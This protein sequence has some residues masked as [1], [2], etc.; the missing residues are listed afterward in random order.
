M[1]DEDEVLPVKL[2]MLLGEGQATAFKQEHGE[3]EAAGHRHKAVN[4][5]PEL[6]RCLHL[7]LSRRSSLCSQLTG[8]PE[9]IPSYLDCGLLRHESR[10]ILP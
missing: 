7:L 4:A 3:S 1:L 6:G 2:F 10:L 9:K 8:G 5:T